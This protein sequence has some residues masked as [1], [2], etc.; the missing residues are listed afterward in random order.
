[1]FDGKKDRVTVCGLDRWLGGVHLSGSERLWRWDAAH[2]R[3]VN[4]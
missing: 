3:L 4:V 1:V 2:A